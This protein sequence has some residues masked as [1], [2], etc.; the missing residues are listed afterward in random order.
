[1]HL[2]VRKKEVASEIKFNY[3][4]WWSFFFFFYVTFMLCFKCS[5]MNINYPDDDDCADDFKSLMQN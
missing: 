1:M 5:L 2:Q 3:D 4:V